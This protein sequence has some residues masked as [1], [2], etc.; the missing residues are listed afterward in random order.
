[1]CSRFAPCDIRQLSADKNEILKYMLNFNNSTKHNVK[2]EN[3]KLYKINKTNYKHTRDMD[4]NKLYLDDL[5]YS[6]VRFDISKCQNTRARNR[7]DYP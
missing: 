2:I 7:M 6:P 4:T 3:K 1:M 5:F